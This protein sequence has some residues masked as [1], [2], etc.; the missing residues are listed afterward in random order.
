MAEAAGLVIGTVAL[1]SL[2]NTCIEICEYIEAGKNLMAEVRLALTKVRLLRVRLHQWGSLFAFDKLGV[3]EIQTVTPPRWPDDCNPIMDGLSQ[4]SLILQETLHLSGRY[5]LA[6][7]L[8]RTRC[9]GTCS[10]RQ[11]AMQ[12]NQMRDMVGNH[13]EDLKPPSYPASSSGAKL[14]LLR[15]RFSWAVKDK[16]K[17][18]SCIEN[19]NFLVTS[20]EGL[21]EGNNQ[22]LFTSTWVGKEHLTEFLIAGNSAAMS[23]DPKKGHSSN[24]GRPRDKASTPNHSASTSQQ[25][26]HRVTEARS[27]HVYGEI[28]TDSSHSIEGNVGSH[29]GGQTKPGGGNHYVKS[30]ATNRSFSIHGN[31]DGKSLEIFLASATK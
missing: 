26:H 11:I 9:A 22:S 25:A 8:N 27:G 29:E 30:S 21:H 14:N 28:N 20:L 24:Q 12:P 15:K 3:L 7:D 16:K 23:S 13:N 5:R 17:F 2:F 18:D 6:E 31:V 10:H 4:V 19:L 1:A